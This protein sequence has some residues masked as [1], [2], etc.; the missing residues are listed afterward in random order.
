MYYKKSVYPIQVLS[1]YKNLTIF[2]TTKVLNRR[3]VQWAE[4]LSSY[5]FTI[6]YYKGSENGKADTL[7]QK[8]NYFKK[9]REQVKH[10]ILRTNQNSVLIY[11]HMVLA[12]MFRVEN[13][14]FT[15]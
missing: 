14:T 2:I 3:Q 5:N 12:A 7:S 15:E 10:L 8:T 11:N 1:D 9:K 4:E 13:N 6:L